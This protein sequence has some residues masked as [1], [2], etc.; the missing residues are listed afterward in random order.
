MKKVGLV[1]S[2]QGSQ[3][4]G[5]G[6]KLYEES[7]EARD[8]FEEASDVLGIDMRKL[9][10]TG[11]QEQLIHT[12]NTQIAIYTTSMAMYRFYQKSIGIEPAYVAGHSLG[13]YTALTAA[14][15][16]TLRDGLKLVRARGQYMQQAVEKKGG[17]MKCIIGLEAE[18]VE[19]ICRKYKEG[20]G[21]VN[22]SNYNSTMQSVIS[23]D[24]KKVELASK[25]C[26]KLGAKVIELEVK[27]PFHSPYM[28]EA[29]EKLMNFMEDYSFSD[30]TIPVFSNVTARLYPSSSV[31]KEYLK[32]QMVCPVRW[33]EIMTF[34]KEIG[35]ETI[36]EVGPK[37]I[38]KKLASGY[39]KEN[40]SLDV[41]SDVE[42]LMNQLKE[43]VPDWNGF[44]AKCIASA[45]CMK[46]SNSDNDELEQEFV[47]P[48]QRV[49]QDYYLRK[50]KGEEANSKMARDAYTMLLSTLDVK[51]VQESEKMEILLELSQGVYSDYVKKWK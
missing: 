2:G 5:M 6:K 31:V 45:I 26:E 25:E 12:D 18:N 21:S 4:I 37:S 32:R 23:G 22:V 47:K 3:Y 24:S 48:Y 34:M 1:F 8:V 33:T 19:D 44:I 20:N 11:A 13:E 42:H 40:I 50:D 27:A 38:L 10:F 43:E 51:K 16:I 30:M 29:S 36:I 9:C 46:N 28:Q 15:A 41:E 35:V 14:G 7:E 49:K 39:C 17:L